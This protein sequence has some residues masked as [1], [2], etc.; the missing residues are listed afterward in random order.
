MTRPAIASFSGAELREVFAAATVWLERNIPQVNAVNVFPV[1]DGDTGTNMY[2]TMRSTMEEAE[3]CADPAAGAVL[4]A[5][6]HGALMGARGNSGVILSQI[7]GGLARGVDGAT[8]V[9]PRSLAAGLELASAAAY[10]A[11]TKPAEG[12][13]L[14]VI[15]EVSEAV[16]A[17]NDNSDLDSLLETAV[18]TAK[19]SVER[20]PS[21]LPVLRE[22]GVVDAGGLGLSVL[23]EGVLRHVRGQSLE[24]AAVAETVEEDWLAATGARHQTEGS[25]Y[26]YC[27]ELLIGGSGLDVESIRGRMMGLGDS[28]IVVGDGQLIRIHVHTDDPGAAL[29]LG[30]SAGQLV[31]VKVDNIRKQAERFVEMH[32][33]MRVE[34]AEPLVVSTVAVVAGEGMERVFHSLGCTRTISGGPTMNPSTRE[35]VE[36]VDACPTDDVAVLPNDKNIILAARQAQKLTE[37]RLH[38][39]GSR[40]M[41]QGIAALLAISPGEDAKTVAEAMENACGAVR[42]IEITRAVRRSSIGGV[43]VNEGDVI[44]IVDDE[45]KLVAPSPEQAVVRALG[46]LPKSDASLATLYYGAETT[47]AA[48]EELARNIRERFSSYEV[49]VVFG[50]QPHYDYIVSVE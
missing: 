44:A 25:L 11:V 30:T 49:E 2:L 19:A 18:K 15:R 7:I 4:A 37:K 13:I 9:T 12:T 5:M 6:S 41:P 8:D 28:V 3:R 32:K 17:A 42:T 47:A 48:A 43:R 26:G 24:S 22:A 20:T 31:Q 1:P 46:G 33:E 29:S 10:K 39:I 38:V 45:L 50:G 40:S 36:A 23:L 14:T 16:A 35:I 34:A 27:T 21:L